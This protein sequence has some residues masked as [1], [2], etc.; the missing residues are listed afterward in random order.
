MLHGVPAGIILYACISAYLL[1]G[2]STLTQYEI[3][4]VLVYAVAAIGQD[5]LM[6]R[7]GQISLGVAAFML[8]GSFTTAQTAGATWAPFPV[9]LI[10]SAAVGG[11]IGLIIGVSGL[12]FRGL[13]LALSTLALQFIVSY[14]AEEYQASN[15]A[16]YTVATPKMLGVTF[17]QGRPFDFLLLLILGLLMLAMQGLYSRAPGRAWAAIRQ[18]ESAAAV[19]GVNVR[20]WK[21]AAFIGSS[22]V[23]AVAGGLLA[24]QVGQ[25]SYEPYTLDLTISV[26]IMVF[27]GGL[28]SQW[29]AVM[30]ATLVIFL[31]NWL[32]DLTLRLS[33]LPALSSW[34]ASNESQVSDAI[35]GLAL[36]L[37]LLFQRKGIVGVIERIES[38]GWPMVRRLAA[39]WWR[40]APAPETKE[41]S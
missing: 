25:V 18:N 11:I 14:L 7:A 41:V 16:G 29:G 17:T 28:G 36:L 39:S 20:Q 13:Y 6:G 26:L 37:V 19:A 23:T 30:G 33:D 27:V 1:L 10:V 24:Y 40:R 5:W 35:Y 34:L 8:I 9:P 31:P 2:T 3:S 15:Q 12:R 32:Q 4:L 22:A 38:A 21:L